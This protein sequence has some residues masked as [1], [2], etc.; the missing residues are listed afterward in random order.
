M[1]IECQNVPRR[2]LDVL[3]AE[4]RK[5]GMVVDFHDLGHGSSLHCLGSAAGISGRLYFSHL[6]TCLTVTITKNE[7]HFPPMLLAG[8]IRQLVSEA[9]E[10]VNK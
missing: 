8:G 10:L 4:L 3:A 2:A 6:G 9:V 7:G 1:K 5:F